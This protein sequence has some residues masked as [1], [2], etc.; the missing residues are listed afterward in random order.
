MVEPSISKII[1]SYMQI[2]PLQIVSTCSNS[3]HWVLT[4][5]HIWC[6]TCLT[7]CRSVLATTKNL[8]FLRPSANQ[9]PIARWTLDS[10]ACWIS[11]FMTLKMGAAGPI[12]ANL[13]F[14]LNGRFWVL[15]FGNFLF[16]QSCPTFLEPSQLFFIKNMFSFRC[17]MPALVGEWNLPILT[18]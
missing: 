18:I 13:W 11:N 15:R 3:C 10:T 8:G 6:A 12:I 5:N 16:C 17:C 7:C 4:R 2:V 14:P 1:W 9:C